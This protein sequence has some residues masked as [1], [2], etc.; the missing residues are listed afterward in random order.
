MSNNII[1]KG[2]KIASNHLHFSIHKFSD[3]YN[4]DYVE[5]ALNFTE[6]FTIT[7]KEE[8]LFISK[9]K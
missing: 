9:A 7:D 3:L 8:L 1:W 2:Q 5:L 6:K 4:L